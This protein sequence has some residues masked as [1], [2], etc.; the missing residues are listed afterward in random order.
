MKNT[1]Q[2]VS[3]LKKIG[4]E[5]TVAEQFYVCN[6]FFIRNFF[7]KRHLNICDHMPG[8]IYKF[9][10]QKVQTFFWQH[11]IHGR[12]SLFHLLWL[13]NNSSMKIYNFDEYSTLYS[14]SYVF[15]IAFHPDLNIEKIFLFEVLITLLNNS[16][17]LDI[18][19]MKCFH[20]LNQ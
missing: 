3:D 14:V 8:I 5:S 18:Y 12:S 11:E 17:T 16:M 7:L 20:I 15:V 6:K 19:L 2:A 13:W 4:K 1:Y 9:E 10:N